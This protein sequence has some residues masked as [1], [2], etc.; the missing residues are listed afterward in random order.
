MLVLVEEI[1]LLRQRLVL[2]ILLIVEE[3]VGVALLVIEV[4]RSDLAGGGEQG[5][6]VGLEGIGHTVEGGLHGRVLFAAPVHRG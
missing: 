1:L 6:L 5:I 4:K 2:F 3:V